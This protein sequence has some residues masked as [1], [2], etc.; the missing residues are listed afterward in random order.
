[1]IL[2]FM[3]N[4]VCVNVFCREMLIVLLI[5]SGRRR[6][7]SFVNSDLLL[8]QLESCTRKNFVE[9]R[10]S[11]SILR[12][13]EGN[14]FNIFNLNKLNWQY[15]LLK[16]LV[17]RHVC[18]LCLEYYYIISF[19]LHFSLYLHCLMRLIL[20]ASCMLWE[21]FLSVGRKFV[22]LFLVFKFCCLVSWL[23]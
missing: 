1:M 15:L 4:N 23:P 6:K 19:L 9:C 22:P 2:A 18:I 14:L 5:D 12:Q 16:C 7:L 8:K 21:S 13:H 3:H 20:G 17:L 10:L 11:E